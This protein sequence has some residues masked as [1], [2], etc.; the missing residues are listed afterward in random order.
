MRSADLASETPNAAGSPRPRR[1]A[2]MARPTS[3]LLVSWFLGSLLLAFIVVP[4]LGLAISQS[5]GSLAHVAA[6]PEVQRAI[7][8]SFGAALLATCIAATVGVPRRT[9]W[10]MRRSRRAALSRRSSIF[11]S[12]C[13][14]P[15]PASPCCSRSGAR[16]LRRAGRGVARPSVLGHGGRHRC[17][18]VVRFRALYGQRGAHWVRGGRSAAGE[19]GAHT[20]HG[21]VARAVARHAAAG[22]TQHRHG[23]DPDLRACDQRIR[24]GGDPGV[25]SDDGAGEDEPTVPACRPTE[26]AGMARLLLALSLRC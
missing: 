15:W 21:A 19:G 1:S 7:L 14:I 6:L 26:A 13:H 23:P 22:A 9:L 11:R 10:P 2:A 12:P 5:G 25:L 17:R 24:R 4:L 20:R 16:D 3:V 8:L 18:H